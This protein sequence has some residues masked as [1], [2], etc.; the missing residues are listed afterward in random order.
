MTELVYELFPVLRDQQK[1]PRFFGEM[2]NLL[3][4]EAEGDGHESE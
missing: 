4:V 2:Q 3:T 1:A